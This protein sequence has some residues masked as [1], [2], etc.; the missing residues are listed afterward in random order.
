[1]TVEASIMIMNRITIINDVSRDTNYDYKH[2][3]NH[4]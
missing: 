2:I 1:M 3:Y 4:N